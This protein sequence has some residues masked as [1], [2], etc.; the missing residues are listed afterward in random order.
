M[1]AL[2]AVRAADHDYIRIMR[3]RRLALTFGDDLY[4]RVHRL[5]LRQSRQ[6]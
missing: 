3:D 5:S 2:T 6:S 1:I 4:C